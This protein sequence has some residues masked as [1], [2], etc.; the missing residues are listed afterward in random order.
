MTCNKMH[1]RHCLLY[2]LRKGSFAYIACSQVYAE[3]SINDRI[4]H[5]WFQGRKPKVLR[6]GKMKTSFTQWKRAILLLIIKHEKQPESIHARISQTL[7]NSSD[8]N[9]KMTGSVGFHISLQ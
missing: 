8:N 3:D 1:A 7:Q 6:S 2:E 5:E 4:F 9:Q